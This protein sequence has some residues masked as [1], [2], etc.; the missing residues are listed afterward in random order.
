MILI[1]LI[2]SSY[3]SKDLDKMNSVE[4]HSYIEKQSETA[5]VLDRTLLYIEII[6]SILDRIHGVGDLKYSLNVAIPED[7]SVIPGVDPEAI[8]DPEKKLAYKKAIA[9]NRANMK[10]RVEAI[11]LRREA[12]DALRRTISNLATMPEGERKGILER[13]TSNLSSQLSKAL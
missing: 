1:T 13:I 9:R 5:D 3:A 12:R 4:I 7:L 2:Q 8:T 10:K 11:A 6:S